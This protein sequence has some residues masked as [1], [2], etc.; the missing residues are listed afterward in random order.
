VLG[1]YTLV[2]PSCAAACTDTKTNTTT[3][4]ARNED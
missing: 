2:W 3:R 4:I 1:R